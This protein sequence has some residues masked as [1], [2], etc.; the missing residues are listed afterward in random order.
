[1]SS[2]PLTQRQKQGA[3]SRDEILDAAEA[4]MAR[5]GYDGASISAIC[6]E[7][8]LPASSVYWHFGSKE[9]VLA[10]VMERGAARF[11]TAIDAV[12][13]SPTLRGRDGLRAGLL[14]ASHAIAEHPDFLR[15]LVLLLLSGHAEDTVAR[16]R[17]GGRERMHRLIASAYPA[18][19]D[20]PNRPLADSL[21]DAALAM[22]DGAFLAVQ[23]DPRVHYE[24][25]LTQM[26]DALASL[27][28]ADIA[29]DRV[30]ATRM[31]VSKDRLHSSKQRRRK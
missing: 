4:L 28:E 12:G 8:G 15:L 24:M 6:S 25:L 30:D 17:A 13:S 16:V 31:S 11:F 29:R 22:F 3:L 2:R 10:A 20:V 26:A 19:G 23:N 27:A 7:C 21:A 9:G 18:R 1:M 5:Q 14:A